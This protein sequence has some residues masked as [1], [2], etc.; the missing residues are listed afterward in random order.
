MSGIII[1]T[2]GHVDHG[3]TALI[4]ALTGIDT[5]RLK[6]EK[7][8][9]ITIDLGFAHLPLAS[10]L[11]AGVVDVPGHEKF[12]ANM[13]AGAGGIDLALLVVAAD[14]GV[15]P[16]T[17]EHLGILRLLG[18]PGGVVAITKADLVEPE[19]LEM[20]AEDIRQLV[21]GSFLEGAPIQP[22]SAHTGQGLD[23]FRALLS[24]ACKGAQGKAEAGDCR[25]PVDRVFSVD[26]FG[27]VI[28]GTMIEGELREGD[29]VEVYPSGLRTRVRNL[30]VHSKDV[31]M[32]PAGSRVAVNLA[33]VKR[34]DV[35]RGDTIATPGSMMTTMMLD[36]R[37]QILPDSGRIIEN[38]SRLHFYHGSRQ[39][40]CKLVLLDS[41][42][43]SPGQ[44]G[45][46]QLRFTEK[47]AVKKDD[48]F[49]LR[50]Y[51]PLETIGGGI[52][53]DPNPGRRR[54]HN[55]KVLGALRVREQG[56][57]GENLLQIIADGAPQ[58]SPLS[59]ARRQIGLSQSA[60]DKELARLE[61]TGQ[62]L[63]VSDKLA[64][65]S[66]YQKKLEGALG[67]I[68]T[69]YHNDNP[70]LEGM[71]RE[72]LRGKLLPGRDSASAERLLAVF[73]QRE[74]YILKGQ[75]AALPNFKPKGSGGEQVLAGKVEDMF[76]QAGYSPPGIDEVNSAFPKE[77]GIKKVLEALLAKGVLVATSPQIYFHGEVYAQAKERVADFIEREGE[78]TLAQARDIFSTSRKFALALLEHFDRHGLTKKVGD[79]RVLAKKR[80]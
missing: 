12:I 61:S 45:F 38:G 52:V 2:A 18:I 75:T 43:L 34:E 24:E 36:V 5:D 57:I 41:D 35:L 32:A 22:V 48:R 80:S 78:M 7:K 19:W 55:E 8:R 67:D 68:L 40:L 26:G 27:T 31:E 20:V 79:A 59:D 3:K 50:F 4:K 14:D 72:E 76:C 54:R 42:R 60:F 51:S 74:V 56:S 1:G 64:I 53:L 58:L 65:D 6:E 11:T 21:A 66:G 13:L 15:M 23:E 46:A 17:R 9:G 25:I 62:I 47:I 73:A 33:S 71:R 28:T 37:L 39:A 49:V 30:Q 44:E 16:Q 69:A 29:E 70:L 10:G 63:L 77:K